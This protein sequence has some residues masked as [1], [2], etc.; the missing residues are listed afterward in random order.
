MRLK[1][2]IV[3]ALFGAC[4]EGKDCIDLRLKDAVVGK[5]LVLVARIRTALT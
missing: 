2:S 4:G 3:G 5:F 1:D